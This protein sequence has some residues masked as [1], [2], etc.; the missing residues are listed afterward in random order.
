[1]RS[2]YNCSSCNAVLQKHPDIV[3]F[4]PMDTSLITLDIFVYVLAAAVIILVIWIIRLERKMRKFMAGK[5]AKT[6]EDS[7]MHIKAG[8]EEQRGVNKE[9]GLHLQDMDTR[10]EQSLRGVAT[11][12]FNAFE[13]TGEGGRQSFATAFLNE[14]K[15]GVI[16][17]SL[18]GRERFSAFAKPIQNGTTEF[19]LSEE[20]RQVLA[21]A[22]NSLKQ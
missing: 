10:L 21:E 4:S 9:I 3:Y 15:D 2:P 18:Y 14:K 16:I 17:S 22:T 6:L 1:M 12:R 20:E 5:D 8:L 11:I 19:E 7:I 13:G